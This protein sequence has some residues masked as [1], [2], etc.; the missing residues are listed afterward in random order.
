MRSRRSTP[1]KIKNTNKSN[2]K[3]SAN[4]SKCRRRSSPRRVENRRDRRRRRFRA[5]ADDENPQCYICYEDLDDAGYDPYGCGHPFHIACIERW[6]NS[7]THARNRKCPY[8]SRDDPNYVRKPK[9]FP[10]VLRA[11]RSLMPEMDIVYVDTDP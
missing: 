7:G 1:R 2:Y 9:T 6:R 11:L 10:E 5:A 4:K 8:C 3:R